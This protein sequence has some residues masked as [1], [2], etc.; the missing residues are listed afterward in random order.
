MTSFDNLLRIHSIQMK[1]AV[2]TE[3]EI[4]W[5]AQNIRLFGHAFDCITVSLVEGLAMTKG[6]TQKPEGGIDR[7]N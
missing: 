2:Q 1:P 4:K 7:A 5:H 3:R 6:R